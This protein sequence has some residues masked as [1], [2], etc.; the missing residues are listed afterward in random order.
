MSSYFYDVTKCGFGDPH[1]DIGAVIN[2]IIADVKDKQ[3]EA[4]VADGGM[5]GAVVYIPVGDYH[6]KTQVLVDVSYLKIAGSGHGF[7][8]SS[9]RFNIPKREWPSLHHLWPG[10]SRVLVDLSPEAG[11]DKSGAAFLVKREG[12]PR[13]SSVEFQNFCIDGLHFVNEENPTEAENSY[14]NG[15]CGI[16]V[17]SAH[18][19]FRVSEMGLV[20]LER[21]LVMRNADALSVH[22]NFI[23]ECGSCVELV[24]MGQAVKITDNLIGAGYNGY[25][26]SAENYAGV[27][28]AANN[29]F[30]RGMSSVRLS[31]VARSSVTAN[32]L[33]SFYPGMLALENGCSDILVSSNHL[34]RD[35]EP[36]APMLS[37]DNGLDDTYGL[38]SVD[39][40]N[41]TI[42]S[43]HISEN[44]ARSRLFPEG[45]RP[46]VI[47]VK[48]GSGNL[49]SCN[50]IVAMAE[51]GGEGGD[52][53][54]AC[55]E[56]QVAALLS[57]KNNDRLDIVAVK[58]DPESVGNTVL[59]T[60]RE[61]EADLDRSRNAFRALPEIPV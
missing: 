29:V 54:S 59:D 53:A 36:W 24:G 50:H 8:S 58:I 20:Y 44:I 57:R 27:L 49:I 40:D 34:L 22:D 28:I 35:G 6:L 48:S 26:I 10:G 1:R 56:T 33:H 17:D 39:G 23:A 3:R 2:K 14:R 18:D 55:F 12:N 4:D 61:S 5:P 37:Y 46:V 19:S 41:N 52:E 32:R 15:K 51:A 38:V 43:N 13:I 47:R 21:G 30:P 45:V 42:V 16:Y 25:S 11:D 9:I 7:V 31:N 60:A